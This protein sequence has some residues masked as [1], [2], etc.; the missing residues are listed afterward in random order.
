MLT[1]IADQHGPLARRSAHV[2]GHTVGCMG[3]YGS[4]VALVLLLACPSHCRAEL[5]ALRV[6]DGVLVNE[7]GQRVGLLG[8]N[9][10]STHLGWSR[11]Q[12]VEVMKEELTAIANLGFNALRVPLNMGYIEPAPDVFPDDPRY[13]QIMQK[14][15]LKPGF[16]AFLD[17][18][19][20][21]AGELGMYVI[22]EFHEFP[23]NPWRYFLGGNEHARDKPGTAI[24]WMAADAEHTKLEKA[25]EYVPKALEWLARH[26]QGNPT[27]AALEV[28]WNEPV[29]G[30]LN[31]ADFYFQLVKSCAQA[32]KRGDPQRLV[33][34]DT[35]DWGACVNYLPSSSCWKTPWEVDG[36]FPHYYFGMHCPRAPLNSAFECAPA[37]WASWFVGYGKPVFIGEWGDAGLRW[38]TWQRLN[39]AALAPYREAEPT[40][41]DGLSAEFHRT[42]VQSMLTQWERLGVQGTF[43]W[44]WATGFPRPTK[45]TELQLHHGYEILQE[46]APSFKRQRG[47]A[48]PPSLAIVCRLDQRSASSAPRDLFLLSKL[49]ARRYQLPY[50]VIFTEALAEGF[51]PIRY[52]KAI[53][54]AGDMSPD[55]AAAA[56]ALAPDRIVIDT[57]S[58]R[59]HQEALKFIRR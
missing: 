4:L 17:A 12:P 55:V 42:M 44:A 3:R 53:I 47:F 57:K 56:E 30:Q 6:V 14:H 1:E 20:A 31:E 50:H 11:E 52:Q 38:A 54:L 15:G 18:L 23:S 5:S 29:G 58:P 21:H 36:L 41:K 35:Q 51:K 32:V 33:F 16:P 27:I 9:L 24:A 49:L 59:W 25:V 39:E 19:V 8:I 22:P 43:L 2:R 26:Y 7:E 28:P 37:H 48:G 10:F 45:G 46:L 40:L 13:A 34:Q